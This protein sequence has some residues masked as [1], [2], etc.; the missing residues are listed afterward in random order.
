MKPTVDQIRQTILQLAVRGQLVPQDPSDEPASELLKQIE[1]EKQK[2]I[3]DGTIRKQ[4][5]LPQITDDETPFEIPESWDWIKM[6]NILELITD[7]SH[8]SPAT[9]GSGMPYITVRDIN[10]NFTINTEDSARISQGDYDDLV[11]GNCKPEPRD[12]LFSKDGTVGKTAIARPGQDF[13]VLS[14]LAILRPIESTIKPKYLN[15]ALNAASILSA[16]L[17][18]KTGVA[19]RRVVLRDLKNLQLPIPPEKEQQRIVEKV[20]ELMALCDRLEHS[21]RQPT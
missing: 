14:S 9:Q 13:V 6:G 4:K 17:G 21:L 18:M 10:D 16:V 12:V 1:A 15:Y 8:H 7:G 3:A 2:L 11:N 20:D 19:I 5:K